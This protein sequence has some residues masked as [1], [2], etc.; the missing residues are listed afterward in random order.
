MNHV[1]HTYSNRIS[2]SSGGSK[3]EGAPP[4]RGQNFLNF[5]QFFGKFGKIICG[6][7]PGELAL[8]PMRNPG[9]APGVMINTSAKIQMSSEPI[10]SDDAFAPREHKF[11]F[12]VMSWMSFM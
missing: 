1:S 4:P 8:P 3:G 10:Q 5:M 6:R 7:P 12:Q 2:V 11:T 9:S